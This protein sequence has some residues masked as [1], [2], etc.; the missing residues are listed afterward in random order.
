MCVPPYSDFTS[1]SDTGCLPLK[2]NVQHR[3]IKGILNWVIQQSWFAWVNALHNLSCK[4]SLKVIAATS[5][6]I[7]E[8]AWLHAVYNNGS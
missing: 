1:S 2:R 4:K 3:L 8:Q 6:L 7:S 5:G